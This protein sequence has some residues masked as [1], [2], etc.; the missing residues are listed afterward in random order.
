[1]VSPIQSYPRPRARGNST[2]QW[3][4][5]NRAVNHVN[6]PAGPSTPPTAN[7]LGSCPTLNGGGKPELGPLK[8]IGTIS[9]LAGTSRTPPEP[10]KLSIHSYQ[11]SPRLTS[12]F[13][14]SCLSSFS[15]AMFAHL[16]PGASRSRVPEPNSVSARRTQPQPSPQLRIQQ[17][18]VS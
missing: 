18:H 11:R 13:L 5:W 12:F 7:H 15:L 1:M 3:R 16:H 8:M 17:H 6:R 10:C 14:N 4:H 2:A 9:A